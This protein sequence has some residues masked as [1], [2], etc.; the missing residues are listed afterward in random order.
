MTTIVSSFLSNINSRKDR[1][2]EKYFEYGKFLLQTNTQKIIF[3]DEP[4]FDEFKNYSNEYT[5]LIPIQK[6]SIYLY[7]Y[8]ELIT[9]CD[10]IYYSSKS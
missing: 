6:E 8:K 3:I 7:K 1:T 4:I 9:K 2:A 5:Y 10:F